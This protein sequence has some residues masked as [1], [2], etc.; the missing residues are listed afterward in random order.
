LGLT[1]LVFAKAEDGGALDELDCLFL[2]LPHGAA[3]DVVPRVPERV[4]IVDLS[5]D[6]RLRESGVYAA[7]YK[8]EHTATAHLEIS[9]TV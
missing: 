4:K 2:A 5:G 8:R 3:L 7:H 6:F 1:D 9:F